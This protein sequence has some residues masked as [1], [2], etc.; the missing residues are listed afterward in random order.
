MNPSRLIVLNRGTLQINH[1]GVLSI[2][3]PYY[4]PSY[5]VLTSWKTSFLVIKYIIN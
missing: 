2:S 4:V 5:Y 1:F 3:A